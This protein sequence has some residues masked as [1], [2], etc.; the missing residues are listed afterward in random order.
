MNDKTDNKVHQG[1]IWFT[2]FTLALAVSIIL[3]ILSKSYK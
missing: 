3:A 1:G 2:I